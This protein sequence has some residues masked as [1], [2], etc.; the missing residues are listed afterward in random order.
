MITVEEVSPST[1]AY[2][3]GNY[4]IY[5]NNL[6][7]V[8]SAIAINDTLTI[9]T[10]AIVDDSYSNDPSNGLFHFDVVIISST[11]QGVGTCLMELS[12]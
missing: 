5:N 1:H 4:L 6:Y 12:S 11:N 10:I 9:S 2:Q 7:K 8:I 3:R